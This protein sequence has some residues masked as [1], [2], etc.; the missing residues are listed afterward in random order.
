MLWIDAEFG[1]VLFARRWDSFAAAKHLV[2]NNKRWNVK[3]IL[4]T[5]FQRQQ[6]INKQ[7]TGFTVLWLYIRKGKSIPYFGYILYV[8]KFLYAVL[9]FISCRKKSVV[10]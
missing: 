1:D 6:D 3:T 8:V 2:W 10:Y 4:H 7:I 9:N 5:L